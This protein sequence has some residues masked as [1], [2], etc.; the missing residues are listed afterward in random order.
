[1]ETLERTMETIETKQIHDRFTRALSSYDQHA[2]AQHLISRK[3]TALLLQHT[4]NSYHRLLEIGCGT[5]GF[6]RY[7]KENCNIGQWVVNDLCSACEAKINEL[8]PTS[9]PRFIAGD[10]ESMPFPGPFDLIASASAFQWIKRPEPFL[11]KIAG[12][13]TPG[14]TLLFS[15]FAP[16][17]LKEIKELT[18]KG[19]TYPSP[20]ELSSW[21]TPG[22]RLLHIEEET[23]P[24]AFPTP[25]E[26]LRHLK[27]TGVTATGS[28][29]WTRGMQET[30]CLRYNELFRTDNNQVT[31]TYRP[32]YVVA[33]KK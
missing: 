15:T 31:L 16:G 13:L 29:P 23:I 2:D 1:M 5:G 6:T 12:L 26:V 9:T 19:L 33:V 30:F 11:R 22:F 24:L 14:G 17:N 4:G 20:S 10:A 21:L 3:L 28:T 8:L 25:L 32:V 18:G 27:N 7:L